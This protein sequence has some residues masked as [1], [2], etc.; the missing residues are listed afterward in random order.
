MLG[1]T[2]EANAHGGRH[3]LSPP[4]GDA[5]LAW[6]LERMQTMASDDDFD[7]DEVLAAKYLKDPSSIYSDLAPSFYVTPSSK[8]H[9]AW[10]RMKREVDRRHPF[11]FQDEDNLLR[12]MAWDLGFTKALAGYQVFPGPRAAT[13]G[14]IDMGNAVNLAKSGVDLS[15]WQRATN[16][17][18]PG[19][20]LTTLGAE[21]AVAMQIVMAWID[22][23]PNKE[24][25]ARLGMDPGIVKR[26]SQAHSLADI[27]D[28]DL[29]YL[30]AVLG[31]ELSTW[32]A[33]RTN[34]FGVRELPTPLRI[35]R[36]TMVH[37]EQSSPAQSACAVGGAGIAPGAAQQA[38]DLRRPI[39]TTEATDR[40]VYARYRKLRE[41]QTHLTS[42]AFA[43]PEQAER[44]IRFLGPVRPA[45][46]SIFREE[47]LDF[48]NHAEVVEAQ[49]AAEAFPEEED[50]VRYWRLMERANL[51]IC[52][53][54]AR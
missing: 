53:S 43:D 33:G 44:L 6:T 24:R 42:D 14:H 2:G 27:P 10:L 26:F 8:Q 13:P 35:A 15:V 28:R 18:D 45:W 7:P 16:L 29:A 54:V 25:F 39:C 32:R 40:A 48:A 30:A 36:A 5:Y 49:M 4:A 11:S 38:H 37:W 46:A 19:G 21:Y 3:Y 1:A 20:S 34:R 51:L 9:S 52:K 41:Y 50:D 17:A 12:A 47:A 23:E 22:S 31:S